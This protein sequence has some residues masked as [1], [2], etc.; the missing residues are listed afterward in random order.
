ML[1]P[2][3]C[4]VTKIRPAMPEGVKTRSPLIRSISSKDL[5]R[6]GGRRNGYLSPENSSNKDAND[7]SSEA[8]EHLLQDLDNI[9]YKKLHLGETSPNGGSVRGSPISSSP[10]NTHDH[11]DDDQENNALDQD[12]EEE[13]ENEDFANVDE[14]DGPIS[15][16]SS[17]GSLKDLAK[18][19]VNKGTDQTLNNDIDYNLPV[20]KE[21]QNQLNKRAEEI[22]KDGSIFQSSRTTLEWSIQ[23]FYSLYDELPDWFCSVDY[24]M[25]GDAKRCFEKSFSPTR[26]TVEHSYAASVLE[27]LT[28]DLQNCNNEASCT[29]SL[30]Y[31]CMGTFGNKKSLIEHI[32]AIKNNNFLLV[33]H[34]SV[35]LKSFK[36]FASHC[37]EGKSHLKHYTNLFFNCSTILFFLVNVLVESKAKG[38]CVTETEAAIE[39]IYREEI[40]EFVVKYIEYWRWNSRLSM[41]IRIVIILFHRLLLLQFGDMQYFEEVKEYVHKKHNIKKRENGPGA[42]AISPLD[43]QA[44]REDVTSRFPTF[45]P[46]ESDIP[47]SFD[48]SNSLSQFL[49]I[50]RPKSKSTL[51]SNLSAPECHI[52]TP[53]PSPCS[54]PT[55]QMRGSKSRKSFQTNLAY[56]SLYPCDDTDG[57]DPLSSRIRAPGCGEGETQIPFSVLEATDIL[58]K[59][60]EIKLSTRQLWHERELFMKQERGWGSTH[61]SPSE[62]LYHYNNENN[63]EARTMVRIEEFYKKCLP[64]LSSIAYVLLQTMESNLNNRTYVR[65]D[66]KD[67]SSG[68]Q[69]APQL[70]II[71]SKE[72]VLKSSCS[73]LYLLMKW[74]KLSHILKF[75]QFCVILHDYKLIGIVTS[76]LNTYTDKYQERVFGNVL[77][78]THSFWKACSSY[79]ADSYDISTNKTVLSHENLDLRFLNTVVYLLRLLSKVTGCKTQRLKELPLAIGTLLKTFY[80]IFNL[81]IYQPILKITQELTP[82]KNKKWKSEHMD[83]ISGVYL[84]RR[85]KLSDNWVTGKDITGELNDACG[86]EIALRALLQFYNFLHYKPSI[87]HLGY[88]DKS[89]FSFFSK[90]AEILTSVH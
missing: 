85:L 45:V 26:F 89:D 7:S 57:S 30:A 67:E 82:F 37:R 12:A 34:L 72:I 13:A 4:E 41:R 48:N 3:G 51:N 69:T 44:F 24:N 71:R 86:Q 87:E 46:P 88:H 38:Q 21:F 59:N 66:T 47:A 76:L 11:S 6:K 14:I 20:D 40:L 32:K 78:P 60:V 68:L 65:D 62:F 84:Y 74:L 43:Y 54:S 64:S 5:R 39:E 8:E 50:P 61:E 70:E 73:S 19:N 42:L 90:E 28:S 35:L 63:G 33:P 22:E 25:L 10:P 15:P 80:Q 53:V 1:R 16:S 49:E 36:K 9:L 18:A 31:I 58:H 52:A 23:D 75:E 29:L 81:D 2:A 55:S 56:P 27:Q 83:L 77:Q 17:S 79:N